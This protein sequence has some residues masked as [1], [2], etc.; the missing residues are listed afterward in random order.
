MYGSRGAGCLVL[1]SGNILYP[2]FAAMTTHRAVIAAPFDTPPGAMRLA[3]NVNTMFLDSIIRKS[4]LQFDYRPFRRAH[5]H[6]L[7]SMAEGVGSSRGVRERWASRAL[8]EGASSAARD[9]W[10]TRS[11]SE[12]SDQASRRLE[13]TQHACA[14]CNKSKAKVRLNISFRPHCPSDYRFPLITSARSRMTVDL[15]A[16]AAD[17]GSLANT[18]NRAQG[19]EVRKAKIATETPSRNLDL[20]SS[21]VSETKGSLRQEGKLCS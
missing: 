8:S 16:A 10:S 17:L 19:S 12:D 1:S 11:I 7:R 4:T 6:R 20:E 18:L 14:Q 3:K 13:R 9:R 15:V 21:I 2:M 5:A